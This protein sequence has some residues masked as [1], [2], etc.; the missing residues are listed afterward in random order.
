[1]LSAIK[2]SIS[3]SNAL[4]RFLNGTGRILDMERIPVNR[5][6]SVDLVTVGFASAEIP[7]EQGLL[8]LFPIDDKR[9]YVQLCY[10]VYAEATVVESQVTVISFQPEFFDQF[11]D[12]DI[13]ANYP[14]RAG[15]TNELQVP[16]CAK[17]INLLSQLKGLQT[18]MPML[19]ALHSAQ[20]AVQLLHMALECILAPDPVCSLPACGFLEN[21]QEREKILDAKKIL[22][23][24][25]D[26]NVTI[27]ELSRMVAINECYL[28]KG[29]KAVTGK[30]IHDYQQEMRID[31]AKQMLGAEGAT[32]TE[33]ADKLGYSSISHFS[34]AFK[35]VTGMKP[36]ELLM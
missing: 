25:Q 34:T 27:R 20:K 9:F 2:N 12:A 3:H 31:K 32:V 19:K 30:T 5:N 35:R 33:V 23:S 15:R 7:A 11:F 18:A 6:I 26:K 21:V 22:D 24:N 1:V 29:F 4:Q 8:Y 14:F 10:M 36:C 16:V 17:T 28:K 13:L